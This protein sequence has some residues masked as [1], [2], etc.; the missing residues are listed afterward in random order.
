[1][2][3]GGERGRG[4]ARGGG[5]GRNGVGEGAEDGDDVGRV[6]VVEG[7]ERVQHLCARG[8]FRNRLG[9]R[10]CR[11]GTQDSSARGPMD[12]GLNLRRDRA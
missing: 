11:G 6:E 5:R 10:A 3:I 9:W 4:W 8:P 12:I 7:R 2:G 1:M